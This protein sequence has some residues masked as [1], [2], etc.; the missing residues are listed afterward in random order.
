MFYKNKKKSFFFFKEQEGFA[1][2]QTQVS[3]SHSSLLL[4]WMK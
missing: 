2:G 4:D 1:L 3:R